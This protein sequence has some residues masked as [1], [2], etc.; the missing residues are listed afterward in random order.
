MRKMIMK[1]EAPTKKKQKG[2]PGPEAPPPPKITHAQ[3]YVSDKFVGWQEALLRALQVCRPL[4]QQPTAHCPGRQ[5]RRPRA[6]GRPLGSAVD[7][8]VESR[9]AS[10]CDMRLMQLRRSNHLTHFLICRPSTMLA[11]TALLLTPLLL[12]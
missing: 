8:A 4:H 9:H 7:R 5:L 10:W 12:C 3:I 11:A 1:A 2:P 6:V